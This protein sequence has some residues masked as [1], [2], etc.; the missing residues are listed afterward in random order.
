MGGVRQQVKKR[1]RV[2]IF[3]HA[4]MYVCRSKERER[5]YRVNQP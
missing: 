4:K 5:F 2:S 3:V 1:E